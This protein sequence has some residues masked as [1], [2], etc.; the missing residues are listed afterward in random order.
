MRACVC[1]CSV[2]PVN[3]HTLETVLYSLLKFNPLKVGHGYTYLSNLFKFN[4][5]VHIEIAYEAQHFK[6]I[7][8]RV[9]CL[10]SPSLH[11]LKHMGW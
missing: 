4:L 5:L 8:Q 7:L 1:M 6:S 10:P 11:L 2:Y 9:S 3:D